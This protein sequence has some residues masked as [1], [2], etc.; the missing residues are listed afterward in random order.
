MASISIDKFYQYVAPHIVG[1][2]KQV[3]LNEIMGAVIEFC[4]ETDVVE[5]DLD[6]VIVPTGAT[7]M[8]LDLPSGTRVSRV[9]SLTPQDGGPQFN[10]GSYTLVGSLIKFIA[11]LPMDLIIVATIALK[12]TRSS[13]RC[14]D[15]LFEDWLDAIVAGTLYKL[16]LMAGRE[17]ADTQAAMVNEAV[18]RR[19]MV[20]AKHMARTKRIYGL[21]KVNIENTVNNYFS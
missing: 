8:E 14:D 13:A 1:A 16:K 11:P 17:W 3:V 4:D 21:G 7:E 10:E 18:F 12:P 19:S 2:P 5:V 6:P 9:K 20:K 15:A